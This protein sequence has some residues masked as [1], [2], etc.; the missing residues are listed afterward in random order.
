MPT[1]EAKLEN[2]SQVVLF[3]AILYK[4][5][6]QMYLG[7]ICLKDSLDMGRLQ[8]IS[9][10]QVISLEGWQPSKVQ[11]AMRRLFKESEKLTSLKM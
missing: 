6:R 2:I 11:I 3:K 4:A 8:A 7:F 5:N 9:M 1:D 10:A